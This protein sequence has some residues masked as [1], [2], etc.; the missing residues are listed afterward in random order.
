VEAI[1][2]ILK[3]DKTPAAF[4]LVVLVG[5]VIVKELLFRFVRKEGHETESALIRTD[6]W[7]HR[8]DAITSAFA[9]IGITIAL[10]GGPKYAV[11]D[12]YA[13][14]LAAMV[15]A[16]NGWQLL[17]PAMDELMDTSPGRDFRERIQK[18]ASENPE[19][20]RVEKCLVRKMGYQYFVDMHIEVDPSMPVSRAHDVAHQVKDRIRAE[21]PQ[22]ADVLVHIEP[23]RGGY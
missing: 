20:K 9:F 11:A 5:V 21:I 17:R 14:L 23:V 12:N 13:A 19:V 8:S 22:V 4:T 15:I 1:R 3:P 7:H 10:A 6:A 18:L 2:G 16:Y